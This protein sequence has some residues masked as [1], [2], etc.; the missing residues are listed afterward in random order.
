MSIELWQDTRIGQEHFTLMN[1]EHP[2]VEARVR[3]DMEA[4][5]EVYYDRRWSI[6]QVL[7]DW[8]LKNMEVFR[9][10]R[11][12]VLGAGVGA[13]ALVLARHAQHVWVNDLAP[14]ALELCAEQLNKNGLHNYTE[15]LGRYETL[16]FPQ[17]D[18]VVAGF[19]IYNK[20]TLTAMRAFL[21]SH[22]GDVLLINERLKQFR[23]FL[24]LEPHKV[25]F[26]LDDGSVGILIKGTH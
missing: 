11:V 25:I 23:S 15:L 10:K 1:L 17:V 18:L 21:A 13:E 7:T 12:L 14:A 24:K 6:T 8:L 20:D 16:E 4:G 22:Q 3:S 9:G 5:I 19:L 2:K 26:D